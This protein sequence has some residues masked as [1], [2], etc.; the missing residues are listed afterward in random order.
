MAVL[1]PATSDPAK[2][3]ADKRGEETEGALGLRVTQCGWVP[4]DNLDRFFGVL[5]FVPD[6]AAVLA[7]IVVHDVTPTASRVC[8]DESLVE[9][10]GAA[11]LLAAAKVSP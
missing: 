5:G 9:A 8:V 6:S 2:R 11:A 1:Q 3:K 7:A 10:E 4:H